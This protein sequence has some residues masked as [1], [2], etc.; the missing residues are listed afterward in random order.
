MREGLR[1]GGGG[2]NEVCNIWMPAADRRTDARTDARTEG[3]ATATDVH[4]DQKRMTEWQAE[5]EAFLALTA[6]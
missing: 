2:E 6:A 3:R 4:T 5:L 1:E